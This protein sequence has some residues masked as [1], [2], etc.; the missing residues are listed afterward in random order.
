M[1]ERLGRLGG[2]RVV[3]V[4]G[5]QSKGE[6]VG[7][8]RS[9]ALLFAREG[10]RLLL[11][12]K[13]RESAEETSAMIAAEG[14]EAAVHQAD[15]TSDEQCREMAAVAER[16]LGGIDVLFNS[17]GIL[18]GGW[19]TDVSVE[20]WD[21]VMDVNLKGMWLSVKHVIPVM[22]DGGGGSIV[23]ISSIAGLRGAASVYGISKA[24]VDRLTVGLAANYARHNIRANAILPGLIDTPMA[25]EGSIALNGL[26][27]EEFIAQ[28]E[29]S[30]PM[31]YKG[32]SMDVAYAALFFASD[33]SRY[34]SGVCMPVDGAR[35]TRY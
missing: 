15:I 29:A 7:M 28:R 19:L 22:I 23:F 27:R 4:G 20:F 11:V 25:I 9:A 32:S 30:V 26:T 2:K 12:D 33:E 8:G 31:A 17:V 1:T 14:G 24:G 5:G 35:T 16:Q 13:D 10:A 21:V 18:G 34:V 3:L 6:A